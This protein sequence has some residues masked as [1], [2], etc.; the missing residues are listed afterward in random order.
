MPLG[1]F[2]T[3]TG[4]CIRMCFTR[5]LSALSGRFCFCSS[6][7]TS[8]EALWPAYLKFLILFVAGV[9]VMH[10]LKPYGLALF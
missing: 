1:R 4:T 9:A 6:T 8:L 10:K 5:S 2:P 7:S 3:L